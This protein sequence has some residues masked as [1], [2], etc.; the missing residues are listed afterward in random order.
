MVKKYIIG[1]DHAGYELKNCLIKHLSD[2]FIFTVEDIGPFNNDS[3]DYPEYGHKVAKM[4]DDDPENIVGILICGTG[5]GMSIVANRYLNVKG[6]LVHSYYTA[7]M[8]RKHNDANI[9]IFGARSTTSMEAKHL[10]N[11]FLNSGFE[12]GRHQR[13]VEQI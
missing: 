7:V 9:I 2:Q 8:A 4:V 11:I 13:R 12:G 3:V 6:A 1:S 5:I 10:L